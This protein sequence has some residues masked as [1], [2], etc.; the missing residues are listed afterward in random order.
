MVVRRYVAVKEVDKSLTHIISGCGR[1]S[2]GRVG[3]PDCVVNA[4]DKTVK[5][6]HRKTR[7]VQFVF[8]CKNRS[9]GGVTLYVPWLHFFSKT[10]SLRR[11]VFSAREEK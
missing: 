2:D 11:K 9:A 5:S 6:Q 3:D 7:W 4:A 10:R 1:R 8:L